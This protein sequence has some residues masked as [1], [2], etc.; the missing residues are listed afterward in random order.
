M[1]ALLELRQRLRADPSLPPGTK[2]TFLPFFIKARFVIC[3]M[4]IFGVSLPW[5]NVRQLTFLPFFI[6]ARFTFA[7]SCAPWILLPWVGH[8]LALPAHHACLF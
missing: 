8:V 5:L 4:Y 2:L 7:L 1:D 6:E 3:A